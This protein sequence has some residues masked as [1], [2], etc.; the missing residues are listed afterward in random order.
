[1][2]AFFVVLHSL[3]RWIVL[4]LAVIALFR[5]YRGWLGKQ[6]WT[7]MDRKI[8]VF[9]GAG[10]DTQLLLGGILYFLG[11]WGV[12]AFAM[13]EQVAADQRMATLFFAVEHTFAMLVAVVLVHVGSV[14][15]RKAPDDASKHQRAAL[16][17]TA[18]L[19]L[20][21]VA[22]PWTQRALLPF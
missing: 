22:I 13:A 14:M 18:A 20:V 11:N 8:G 3:T 1:M 12:K 19:L 9:F 7:E 17:F 10:M 15:S 4:V 21:M 6:P 5:A 16:W 2:L